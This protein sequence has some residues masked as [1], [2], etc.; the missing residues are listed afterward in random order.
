MRKGI[1]LKIIAILAVLIM[2]S[3]VTLFSH[4]HENSYKSSVVPVKK[5]I[6]FTG[7]LSRDFDGNIIGINNHA[8][9]WGANNVIKK[10]YLAYNETDLFIGV[11][12]NI[13]YNSLMIFITNVTNDIYGTS[14][15]SNMNTWNRDIT[16]EGTMNYFSAVYFDGNNINPAGYGTYAIMSGKNS[17]P[18][19]KPINSTFAFF[20]GNN[21]TE[22][23]IP[24][25]QM[26]QHG[27]NGNLSFGISAFVVGGSGPWVGSGIPYHQKGIYNDGNQASFLINDTIEINIPGIHVSPL[28]SY[29]DYPS[30]LLMSNWKN[31]DFWIATGI[32]DS[33]L[34]NYSYV[35]LSMQTVNIE[36]K[37]L[38][39][40]FY[41][42]IFGHSISARLT[43]NNTI[44]VRTNNSEFEL[45]DP[46]YMN[47]TDV[48]QKSKSTIYSYISMPYIKYNASGNKISLYKYNLTLFFVNSSYNINNDSGMLNISI[49]SGPGT[50]II[51]LST[52][53]T[54]MNPD[55]IKDV[56]HA[57]V[58]KWLSKSKVS[59]SGRYLIE[60][61][62]SQLL[63][64][65]DQNPFTGE[66]VASPS[67]V[68]FYNWV[69]DASFSAISL[70]DSGHIRS[71]MKYWDF[72]AGVQGVDTYNGTWQTRFNFWNG[73]VAG[74]V[75]PEFDSVGLFEIGIYNL[76]QVT[77]NISVIQKFMPNILASLEFQE[78]SIKKYGFIAEDHSIWEMEYGYWFWT[79]AIN[80][81]G[82]RD[83]SRM[84][85][86]QNHNAVPVP[87][88]P[89][90]PGNMNIAMIAHKL[91]SNIIKYF[92]MDN[93]FAQYLVP[94]TN[95]YGN[96]NYTYFM[97]NNTPDSSQIL[98]IAMGFI[99][100]SS[101]MATS[102]VH[103][104]YMIL[105][106]YRV[107]GLPRYYNDL[108][109]YTEYG[110]YHESSGPSPPW[111][112]TTLFLALYDEKT[113]NMTGALNLM[114]WSYS[115]SQSWLLPEAVDPNFGSVIASTSPLTW[116]SA[117][118]IIVSLNYRAMPPAPLPPG[119]P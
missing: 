3:S 73:S 22:I 54:Y 48:I 89:V 46:P 99:N 4:D 100:P 91:K 105:W 95:Q 32:P 45:I 58:M 9:P 17:T 71:A 96:N 64:K 26:F 114:K 110:G 50:S 39:L 62:M 43:P 5:N 118:Y 13:S 88:G 55:Y 25:S 47:Q 28:P 90:P 115:H 6:Y 79:Q 111:I 51:G 68:Y 75:Y 59:I 38:P 87:P 49:V 86:I 112:I 40:K 2:V 37:I 83:I 21:T 116:S 94:V 30:Y 101:P 11:Y 56:N 107:G 92:Y 35:H 18:L 60:Y 117:M 53:S 106:N 10:L 52:N 77:H 15:I 69:R 33:Y 67:P 85:M 61:N 41:F 20:P 93:I 82:I 23:A 119:P 57:N 1:I 84:P 24:F 74:F 42:D 72:M 103:N 97:A 27:F 81:L 34:G 12:E 102:I 14:N 113:G 31:N 29:V 7:N 8:S 108:Y 65:D 104:I 76:F 78:K 19:A 66:I 70:Q 80:Y 44:N 63:V 16:F 36:N 98:P 109:H